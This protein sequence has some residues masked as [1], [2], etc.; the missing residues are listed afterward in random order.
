MMK[1]R[2]WFKEDGSDL[3][4]VKDGVEVA[5]VLRWQES[6]VKIHDY[7]TLMKKIERELDEEV[8]QK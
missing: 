3:V 4:T 1:G 2:V 5:R 8:N 7:I 6:G